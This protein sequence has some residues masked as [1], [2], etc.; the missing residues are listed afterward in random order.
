MTPDIEIL[1]LLL[2]RYERSGHCLPDKSSNRRVAL[3]MSRGEYP[4]YRENDPSNI[5]VNHIIERLSKDGLVSYTWR[6]GYEGWLL[7]KV[8]LNL[9]KLPSAYAKAGRVPLSDTASVL[10]RLIRQ[11]IPQIKTPWKLQFL[12]DELS[13]L[14]KS[15]R[16]SR[17]L[18][19]ENTEAVLK[20]LEYTERG[21]NLMRVISANCFHDSKYLERNLLSNLTSIAK[22]YEPELIAFRDAG[23]ELLTQSVI[24]EQIG[25]L[26]YPEIFEFCGAAHLVLSN[27]VLDISPL[28][29]GFCL[30]SENL[31]YISELSLDRIKNVLLIEN[32]TNYRD[33]LM[34]GFPDDCFIVWHGGFYSPTKKRLFQLMAEFLPASAEVRFWGDIDLGGFLMFTRLKEGIFHNLIPYRMGLE[35][36]NKYKVYGLERKSAYLTSLQQHMEQ[37]RFDAVFLPVA[38]EILSNGVTIEQEIIL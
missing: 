13:K 30:Q 23:D 5:E 1:N 28:R 37:K 20:I 21:S 8:Y 3:A 24:L 12:E 26:T 18:D 27:S 35:D 25:I 22:A 36:Y 29:K 19:P 32:R 10:C 4:P 31:N 15:L 33:F 2:D 34:R 9:E 38:K 16:P 6:K 14:E 11:Y 17:H 7:D